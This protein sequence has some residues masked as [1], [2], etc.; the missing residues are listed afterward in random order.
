MFCQECGTAMVP[1]PEPHHLDAPIP[2]TETR[3]RGLSPVVLGVGLAAAAGLV[4]LVLFVAG[5]FG[6]G[7]GLGG[8]SDEGQVTD[9]VKRSGEAF[10]DRDWRELYNLYSPS[11]RAGCSFEEFQQYAAFVFSFTGGQ[12]LSGQNVRVEVDGD[13]AVASYDLYVGGEYYDH[14]DGDVYVKEDGRWYDVDE[15]AS[16]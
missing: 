5:T 4:A 14:E 10:N 9:L 6:G 11:E 7:G 13:R 8:G 15:D 12:E 3:Q 1:M 16:C 2:A